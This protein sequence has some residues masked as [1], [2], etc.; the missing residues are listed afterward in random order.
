MKRVFMTATSKKDLLQTP[1]KRYHKARW[2]EKTKIL[3]EYCATTGY[4]RK[5]ATRILQARHQYRER[6]AELPKKYTMTIRTLIVRLWALLDYPCGQRLKPMLPILAEQLVRCGELPEPNA[7][8]QDQLRTVSKNTLDRYLRRERQIRRLGR[9]R[10]ATHHGSLLKKAVPIRITNW[11]TM[12]IGFMEMDTVAHCGDQLSGEFIYSL[13]MVEIATGWSEQVAVMGKGE[14]GIVKAIELIKKD[15]PFT[16]K[17][18]D[19]DTGS[20]FVNWHMVKW[21]K[22]H[23]LF[24]TRSRPYMKNDNAYVEQKNYTHI[25]KW[26]GYGRFDTREQLARINDLYRG[27]LRLWNNFFRPVM[28]IKTKQKINNSVCKKTYDTAQTPYQRL[29]T[30]NQI[31]PE[32]KQRLR[33]LYDSLNPVKLKASIEAK[34]KRLKQS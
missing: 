33:T 25:R 7:M 14:A 32:T 3:D 23:G 30:S 12:D 13:D 18:L 6:R 11:D 9:G 34:L 15:L 4:H 8:V 5:Y 21:C 24:F 1:K 22:E 27:D 19:S 20:E 16:L 29:L 2:R 31:P 17:G 28:K 26:L 10:S